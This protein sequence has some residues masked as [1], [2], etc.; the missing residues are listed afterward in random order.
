MSLKKSPGF[1]LNFSESEMSGKE[2]HSYRF[3]AF[4]LDVE[5]RQLFHNGKAAPLTPK[6]FDVLVAL[7]ERSGHLVEKDELLRLVWADSFVEEA[8]IA[9]VVHTLRKTLGEDENGHKFIETVPTRDYRFV[10]GVTQ[11]VAPPALCLNP[12]RRKLPPIWRLTKQ[13]ASLTPNLSA[14]PRRPLRKRPPN[15]G[16]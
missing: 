4:R 6:A 10:A 14:T 11:E 13:L 3:G 2:Q 12:S 7:V 1:L 5:E 15:D 8:N 9:R 16:Y